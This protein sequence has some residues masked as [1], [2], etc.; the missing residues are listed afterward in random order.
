MNDIETVPRLV[1]Q[2]NGALPGNGNLQAKQP[3]TRPG[4]LP[5]QVAPVWHV[6]DRV[7]QTWKG[8]ELFPVRWGC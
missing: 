7:R 2:S 3:P 6:N 5:F 4:L 8:W 1:E